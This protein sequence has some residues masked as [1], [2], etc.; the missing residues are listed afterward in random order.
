MINI[1]A[2]N[3]WGWIGFVRYRSKYTADERWGV[4]VC[5]FFSFTLND[6]KLFNEDNNLTHHKLTKL[7]SQNQIQTSF[8]FCIS[9]TIPA[10]LY[11]IYIIWSKNLQNYITHPNIYPQ[12]TCNALSSFPLSLSSSHIRIHAIP[13]IMRKEHRLGF[14]L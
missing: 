1:E 14:L 2:N 4:H 13:L 8:H 7:K 12:I 5:F 9:P 10:K 3:L 6:T 11:F